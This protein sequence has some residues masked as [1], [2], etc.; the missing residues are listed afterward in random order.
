[1]KKI[2]SVDANLIN[3]KIIEQDIKVYFDSIDETFEFFVAQNPQNTLDIINN[4][5]I[6][7]I[8]DHYVNSFVVEKFCVKGFD[9]F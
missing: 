7:I 5:P 9:L 4:N 8:L 6:D 3:S 2:L 1:M